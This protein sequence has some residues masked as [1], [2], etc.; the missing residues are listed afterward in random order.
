MQAL[1]ISSNSRVGEA[2]AGATHDDQSQE[3]GKV[4]VEQQAVASDDV[5]TLARLLDRVER[6]A[7]LLRWPQPEQSRGVQRVEA[8]DDARQ[9]R[10]EGEM[11]CQRHRSRIAK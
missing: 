2:R 3:D 10:E 8:G 7:D 1:S 4:D 11:Y 6:G 9:A 5:P